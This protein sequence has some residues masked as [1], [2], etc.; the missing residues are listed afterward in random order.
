MQLTIEKTTD[1]VLLGRKEIEAKL[2]YEGSTPSNND[3]AV[4]IAGKLSTDSKLVIMKSIYTRFSQQN[5]DV[6]AVVYKDLES[7]QKTEKTTKHL[8]KK[9]EETK[10]KE[11]EAKAAAEEAKKA[12]EAKVEES[13][14]EVKEE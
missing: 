6:K 5:A 9:M 1:N 13:K 4:A 12:E 3:L 2:D 7:L 11:A 10:K 8:R 14:E